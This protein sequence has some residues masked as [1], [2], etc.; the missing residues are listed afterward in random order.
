VVV[1][2]GR[3]VCCR[4]VRGGGVGTGRGV[5]GQFC[6]SAGCVGYRQWMGYMAVGCLVV[7]CVVVRSVDVGNEVQG[8]G[9]LWGVGL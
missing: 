4:V 6:G 2:W 3:E 7:G 5:R 9:A 8:S 1:E